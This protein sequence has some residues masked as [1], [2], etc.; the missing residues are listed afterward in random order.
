MARKPK[1]SYP[2]QVQHLEQKGVSFALMSKRQALIY[3]RDNNNFFKLSSYRKNFN[4]D[5]TNREYVHLDFAYLVDLAIIDMYL[6]ALMLKMSL[7]IEHFAKV[8]LMRR[9]TND[10]DEDGYS[11]VQ[12][13]LQSLPVSGKKRILSELD[14]NAG[15]PYCHDAYQK[16]N[17]EFPVWVFI[18]MI[19][20]GA[21]LP[22]YRFC[23]NRF[24]CHSEENDDYPQYRIDKAMVD[25]FFLM[26]S[27]KKLRNAAAHNNCVIND[28]K[29]KTIEKQA[30]Y[31]LT[32]ALRADL[33]F[34]RGS[35]QKK[36]TNE[37][38]LQ[39]LTCLYT[40]KRLVSSPGIQAHV[41]KDL[42]EF[43]DR[44]FSKYSYNNNSLIQS[45]FDVISSAIDKWYPIV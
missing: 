14:R 37:R 43:A 20:F 41:A 34:G 33:E 13:Y 40:H 17:G 19:P 4:K 5:A 9:I 31:E 25:D 3:L 2:E 18:E 10:A 24:I 16:Y 7:N 26:K 6:R 21:F 44:L 8:K 11:I 36:I 38:V 27:T 1:L 32:R 28:L 12:D 22:F 45:T 39:I 42:H 35:I 30:N 23:A 29:T 15:S